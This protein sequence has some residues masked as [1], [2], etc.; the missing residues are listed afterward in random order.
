[1]KA[2]KFFM[3]LA[4][5]AMPLMLTTSCDDDDD[6]W[7]GGRDFYGYDDGGY[8][9][10]Q[11]NTNPALTEA[12]ILNGEWD[13]TMQYRYGDT[14]KVDNFRAD[15]MFV[16]NDANSTKGTG[17]EHDY[18]LDDQGNVAADTTLNFNWYIDESNYNI[19]VQY[20]S[21]AEFVMDANAS[22]HGFKLNSE[23]GE[24]Y[25]YMINSSNNDMIY[26]DLKR[27]TNNNAKAATRATTSVSS[28]STFGKGVAEAMKGGTARLNHRR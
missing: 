26:I 16:Q 19:H 8:D 24:F 6:Y 9:G 13:G 27:Q 21:G 1:M 11:D 18:Y 10:G 20:G 7:W 3:A 14:G 12:A 15:M 23:A 5:M 17:T 28:V 22:E 25:G 4:L 2:M